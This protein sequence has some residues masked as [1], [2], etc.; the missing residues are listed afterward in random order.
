MSQSGERTVVVEGP[1]PPR[2]SRSLAR[3]LRVVD[4]GPVWL[5]RAALASLAA[6]CVLA[7]GI[8][9][10]VRPAG[11]LLRPQKEIILLALLGLFAVGV[12]ILIAVIWAAPRRAAF[13]DRLVAPD[14]RA[15]IWL[16]LAVWFPF[17]L[18]AAYYRCKATLPSTIVWI[19]FG[20][21]DKRWVTAT[22]LLGA[23]APMLVLVAAARVLAAGRAHPPSWRAWFR[24]LGPRRAAEPDDDAG[25]PPTGTGPGSVGPPGHGREH[26]SPR[27]C[28]SRRC[29]GPVPGRG[30]PADRGRRPHRTGPGLLL[31]RTALVPE[32][33]VRR[34]RDRYPGR[35]VPHR[36]PGHLQGRRAL[37]RPGRHSVRPRRPAAVLLVHEAR[38]HLL[39]RRLPRVVGHVRVGRGV[40]LLR[41]AVPLA[42]LPPRPFRGPDVRADLP[43]PAADG[44]RAGRRL[45]RVLRLGQ[46]AS[47]R[48]R[49]LAAP[50]AARG[51]QKIARLARPGR[52]RRS[53]R[54]VGRAVL[55]C[56]G[57]PGRGTRRR[58]RDRRAAAAQ[59]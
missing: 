22:Y 3:A 36:L 31:L 35:R 7:I 37:Y 8:A 2:T 19:S 5:Y 43:G 23:L 56:P 42:R 57:E 41:R 12:L 16:A 17:L 15:A 38:R 26:R 48:W 21:M 25:P 11:H 58:A 1:P 45:Q 59:R 55:R 44:F 51:D 20:F 28:G 46:P 10:Y 52:G 39:G 13:L 6:T 54:A 24:E 29:R 4:A 32:P 34:Q 33:H 47:L 49:D 27:R 53:R 40:D 50:A 14:Q 9:L 18:I 30:H